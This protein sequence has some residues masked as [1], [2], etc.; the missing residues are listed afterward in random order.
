M[1]NEQQMKLNKLVL[2]AMFAEHLASEY[3]EDDLVYDYDFDDV[4]EDTTE[5]LALAAKYNIEIPK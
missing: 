2:E 5:I 1:T 4:Y 3:A